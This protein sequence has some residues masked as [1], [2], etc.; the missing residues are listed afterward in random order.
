MNT[1][2]FV[3]LFCTLF[4][5][6]LVGLGVL[7]Q[8][9][10]STN[11]QVKPTEEVEKLSLV[12][13]EN[14]EEFSDSVSDITNSEANPPQQQISTMPKPT[15]ALPPD[16]IIDTDTT[17]A[18]TLET[19]EGNIVIETTTA[20]TPNTVNN[21]IA[22]SK[23]GFY[24]NT[25]FHRVIKGFMIQGGDPTGTGTGGPGYKFDDEPFEGEY[26][27]GTVAMANSGPNTNGSQFFIM[28]EATSLPKNYVIFGH[29]K[30][31]LDVVDKIAEAPVM[32]SPTGEESK[33]VT[34][35]KILKTV[36]DAE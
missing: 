16:R 15:E 17:Y 24:D 33:P 29:V 25:I 21:F 10:I 9:R 23:K 14:T 28:H 30:E 3:I 7:F 1:K 22:L 36:I 27:R 35:V 34:P 11:S 18:V 6:I 13:S 19:T 8:K 12:G 20:K 5:I 31:G 26:T 32:M 4:L 2:V